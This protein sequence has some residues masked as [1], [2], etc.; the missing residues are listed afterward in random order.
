MDGLCSPKKMT[1]LERYLHSPALQSGQF[2]GFLRNLLPEG[3]DLCQEDAVV[4]FRAADWFV[5]SWNR[6]K[7]TTYLPW[8]GMVYRFYSTQIKM[9][10][11]WVKLIINGFTALWSY[12]YI[13][14]IG[15]CTVLDDFQGISCV[16]CV[17]SCWVAVNVMFTWK[18]CLLDHCVFCFLQSSWEL[19]SLTWHPDACCISLTTTMRK[20]S[21]ASWISF[22]G[23]P[24]FMDCIILYSYTQN[25][26]M[27]LW[28]FVQGINEAPSY[29]GNDV[30]SLVK[31]K[32]GWNAP[33]LPSLGKWPW[34][35]VEPQRGRTKRC[36]IVF[37]G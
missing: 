36:P 2:P 3:S 24:W 22:E 25:F 34:T 26:S 12:L 27:I 31:L 11:T 17:H 15:I 8:L 1:Q 6:H 10:M 16:I 9:V 18:V 5:K 23:D 30:Q 4:F 35:S 29:L 32:H 14:Y 28:Y 19:E 20:Q 37:R 21:W 7:V 33:K 13:N